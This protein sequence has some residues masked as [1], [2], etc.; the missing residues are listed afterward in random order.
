MFS[1]P[2]MPSPGLR[3]S[4]IARP[5]PTAGSGSTTCGRCAEDP[6]P[7]SH[8]RESEI[9]RSACSTGIPSA[10]FSFWVIYPEQHMCL[11]LLVAGKLNEKKEV[12]H[13]FRLDEINEASETA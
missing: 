6:G 4:S 3:T 9:P 7:A 13:H 10:R 2:R 1:I 5:S 8:G 11:D 12:T